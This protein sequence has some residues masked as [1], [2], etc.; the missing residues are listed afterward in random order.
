[1]EIT[2]IFTDKIEKFKVIT[3][4]KTGQVLEGLGE[5]EVKLFIIR[6]N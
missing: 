5:Y 1:M 4:N 6:M 3:Q 2:A